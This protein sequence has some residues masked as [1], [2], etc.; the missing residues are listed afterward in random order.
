MHA[1]LRQV[2]VH[3]ILVGGL[4]PFHGKLFESHGGHSTRFMRG[5][6]VYLD[7]TDALCPR[8]LPN[9]ARIPAGEFLMGA[10]DAEDD[11]RPVHRV[12][13]Q[14]VLHRPISGDAGRLRAVRPGHRVSRARDSRPAARHRRRTRSADSSELAA[15]YVWDGADPPAGRG[16]ASR[17]PRPVRRCAGVL[18]V[19]VRDARAAGASADRGRVGKGGARRRRR[20]RAIRGATTSMRRACNFLA[21]PVDEASARHAAD[22]HVPAERVRAVRHGGQRL[23]V[24]VRLVRRATT[25][26][27]GD[28]RDPRGPEAGN[29]RIVRGGSWVNDDPSML[30]CAIPSQGAAGHLRLQHRIPNRMRRVQPSP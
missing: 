29:M 30:R 20:P 4:H 3:L 17:R 16:V 13:R 15:P 6:V 19:A 25:T 24:G 10:A 21:D 18:R 28:M 26:A 7:Y 8:H 2:E 9:L 1:A 22:R 14:R 23:G 5:A 11:E 27:S 12:L